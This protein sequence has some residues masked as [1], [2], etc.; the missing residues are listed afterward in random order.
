MKA[1]T[2]RVISDFDKDLLLLC[3]LTLGNELKPTN[4]ESVYIINGYEFPVAFRELRDNEKGKISR[5]HKDHPVIK[6]IIE[7]GLNLQTKPIPSLI[8]YLTKHNSKIFQLSGAIGKEG[9][10][11]LWKLKIAG[12]ETEE[13]L[14]AT[15]VSPKTKDESAYWMWQC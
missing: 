2:K 10:I 14:I 3:R 12:V 8:F 1:E 11:F 9:F 15:S 7:E 5:A 13:I 4:N 6:K